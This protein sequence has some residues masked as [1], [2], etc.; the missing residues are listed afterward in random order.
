VGNSRAEFSTP[1]RR[2]E[3]RLHAGAPAVVHRERALNSR[4]RGSRDQGPQPAGA[5]ARNRPRPCVVCRKRKRPLPAHRRSSRVDSR[6]STRRKW[7]VARRPALMSPTRGAPD[8]R[9]VRRLRRLLPARSGWRVILNRLRSPTRHPRGA[10]EKSGVTTPTTV[11]AGRSS[12][13][14]ALGTGDRQPQREVRHLRPLRRRGGSSRDH[15]VDL[16]AGGHSGAI[17][18][19]QFGNGTFDGRQK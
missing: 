2:A 12:C 13:S 9:E 3:R 8:V 4:G 14:A 19:Q 11:S 18:R 7:T 5:P 6:P 16:L 15:R 10:E 1:G 17:I